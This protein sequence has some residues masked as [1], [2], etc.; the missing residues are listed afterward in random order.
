MSSGVI[1]R[2]RGAFRHHPLHRLKVARSQRKRFPW[3]L[4]I[5][6]LVMWFGF[7]AVRIYSEKPQAILVL[8]GSTAALEREKFTAEFAREHPGLPIWISSGSPRDYTK[9]V[10]SEAGVDVRRLNLDYQAV[11]TVT[12]FTTLV[13]ELKQQGVQSVYLVTSDYHMRRAQIIGEIVLGS[14]GIHLKPVSVPSEQP[15]EPLSKALRDGGRAVL[16][17]TTGHTGASWSRLHGGW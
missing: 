8:G 12:N 11:D 13:D 9:Q 16:W 10:F 4:F 14:R 2:S 15:Q 17:V 6:P 5:L 3:M 1:M 7:R